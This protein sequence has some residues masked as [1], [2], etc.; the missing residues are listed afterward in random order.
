MSTYC[1]ICEMFIDNE[2]RYCVMRCR[3]SQ[4][5][6]TFLSQRIMTLLNII[7][8]NSLKTHMVSVTDRH[9]PVLTRLG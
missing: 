2:I 5:S 3:R 9:S 6:N 1:E 7:L 4:S 8:L